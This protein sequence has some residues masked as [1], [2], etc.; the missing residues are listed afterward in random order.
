MTDTNQQQRTDTV[1]S[2]GSGS[3]VERK[4]TGK[5]K[6]NMNADTLPVTGNEVFG[7][8]FIYNRS[9]SDFSITDHAGKRHAE[10]QDARLFATG[11]S[12]NEV[13]YEDRTSSSWRHKLNP[14]KRLHA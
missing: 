11:K 7:R 6:K 9:T 13:E 12:Q 8:S 14:F 1:K 2:S 5:R 3:H 4:T 10:E